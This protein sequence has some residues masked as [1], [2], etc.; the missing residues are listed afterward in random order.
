MDL[1]LGAP[2]YG[3]IIAMATYGIMVVKG[4]PEPIMD[5]GYASTSTV[6]HAGADGNGIRDA[7]GVWYRYLCELR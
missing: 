4:C 3:A 7:L 2:E 1:K 5:P 6:I